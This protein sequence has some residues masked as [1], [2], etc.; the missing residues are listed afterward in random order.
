MLKIKK[1]CGRKEKNCPWFPA[2]TQSLH[3]IIFFSTRSRQN[4]SHHLQVPA[5]TSEAT[6]SSSL[7]RLPGCF[8]FPRFPRVGSE[9][10]R[11]RGFGRDRT[12]GERS[13]W[14]VSPS[15]WRPR[16]P[17]R[18]VPVPRVHSVSVRKHLPLSVGIVV[19]II[20]MAA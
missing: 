13:G 2:R 12:A 4:N 11:S 19:N 18:Y 9:D 7:D 17:R 16:S 5:V 15:L 1:R 8:S 6:L 3:V 14:R 10:Q 20:L